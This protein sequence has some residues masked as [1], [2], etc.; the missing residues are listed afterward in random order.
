MNKFTSFY[1][2]FILLFAAPTIIAQHKDCNTALELCDN[3]SM[4]IVPDGGIGVADP[5]IGTTCVSEEFNP[6]W[7]KWT[8]MEDGI[9]S[10]VLTP[11]V[12]EQDLDFVVFQ[13]GGDYDCATKTPIRCMAAGANTGQ[14]P[15]EW[16]NC[17]GSTGL[18]IGNTDVEEQPGC[19]FGNNNFLAPIQALAGDHYIMLINDFS[20]SGNGYYL[21]FTGTAVLGCT[22]GTAFPE[23]VLPQVTFAV[24][25]SVS[26]GT[27]FI[28]IADAGL[29]DS[30]LN[31]FNTE[32]QIVY[33]SE[34]LS[35]TP[36][37]ID[38]HHLP[39]G[40]YFA[41]LRTSNSIQT[42]KFLLTK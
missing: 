25:P 39:P 24:Y 15:N 30:K 33:S 28:R 14:P 19:N 36:F 27:I 31:V 22:T 17:V 40:I 34:K 10:F 35:E 8:V 20:I 23:L 2:L 16:I 21:S 32:G 41:V 5:G 7:V 12:E 11:D 38:L 9:L 1:I 26:A 6:V 37:Q 13:S 4:H 42:Q 3:S 29:P 18:A